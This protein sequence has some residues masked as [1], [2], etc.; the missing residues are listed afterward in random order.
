MWWKRR[1][2]GD[3]GDRNAFC[4]IEPTRVHNVLFSEENPQLLQIHS[5][6]LESWLVVFPAGDRRIIRRTTDVRPV[7]RRLVVCYG[8]TS[9]VVW[10][11][12]RGIHDYGVTDIA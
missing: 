6:Q 8:Y 9:E 4:D 1:S 11:E 10:G 12:T 2:V 3:M 7:G 5:L